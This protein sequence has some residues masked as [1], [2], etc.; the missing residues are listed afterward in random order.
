MT[1]SFGFASAWFGQEIKNPKFICRRR[2]ERFLRCRQSLVDCQDSTLGLEGIKKHQFS[3]FAF[4]LGME[5][6]STSEKKKAGK[7]KKKIEERKSQR[8]RKKNTLFY[9]ACFYSSSRDPQTFSKNGGKPRKK[10]KTKRFWGLCNM[11][12]ARSSQ[13]V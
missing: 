1:M 7:E 4:S 12:N 8:K 11:R 5:H 9:L 6:E 13:A 3:R 2:I 10:N